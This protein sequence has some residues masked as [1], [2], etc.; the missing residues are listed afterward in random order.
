M[1]QDIQTL[2]DIKLMV[3]TFYDRIQKNET[4]GLSNIDFNHFFN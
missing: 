1:K 2:E 4:L 3:N